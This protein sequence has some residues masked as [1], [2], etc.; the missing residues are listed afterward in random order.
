M[1]TIHY[2]SIKVNT[3][4]NSSGLFYGINVQYQWYHQ[5]RH[6]EGFG[7]ING[8]SNKIVNNTSVAKTGEKK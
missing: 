4:Q 5:G 7:R 3:I 1:A 8:H 2:K 6:S